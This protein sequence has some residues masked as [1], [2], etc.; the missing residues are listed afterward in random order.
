MLLF[1]SK[2]LIFFHA[3]N[4]AICFT[5]LIYHSVNTK[6][7]QD[8]MNLEVWSQIIDRLIAQKK[9]RVLHWS[10]RLESCILVA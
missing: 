9:L 1:I 10:T 6:I 7:K 3:A 4:Q 5:Y 8:L 2:T